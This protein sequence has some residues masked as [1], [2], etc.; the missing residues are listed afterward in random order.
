[1]IIDADGAEGFNRVFQFFR[2]RFGIL[3]SDDRS[4]AQAS[5]ALGAALG[6]PGVVGARDRCG[7]PGVL[8][9]IY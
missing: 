8:Q 6:Y 1:M 3:Q 4:E 2:R 5:A 7:E 9:T